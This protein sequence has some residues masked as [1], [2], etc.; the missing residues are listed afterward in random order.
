MPARRPVRMANPRGNATR[1][2]VRSASLHPRPT[3]PTLRAVATWAPVQVCACEYVCGYACTL[4]RSVCG[5]DV[6]RARSR[7][8]ARTHTHTH[9]MRVRAHNVYMD[10]YTETERE[11]ERH[12]HTPAARC[13]SQHGPLSTPHAA[14]HR[15]AASTPCDIPY[16]QQNKTYL[17]SSGVCFLC[18]VQGFRVWGLG[19]S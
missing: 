8:H 15:Q 7:T 18:R 5:A 14:P 17:L 6:H 10:T 3:F 2:L 13:S 9:C 12:R 4:T 1:Y 19:S 16:M 11:T